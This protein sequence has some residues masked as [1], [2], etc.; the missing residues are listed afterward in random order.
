[1]D[2]FHF[3]ENLSNFQ[4]FL[5]PYHVDNVMRSCLSQGIE[6]KNTETFFTDDRFSVSDT[7]FADALDFRHWLSRAYIRVRKVFLCSGYLVA[8]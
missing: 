4:K 2:G 8:T 3:S 5:D 6:Y 1:M 7:P